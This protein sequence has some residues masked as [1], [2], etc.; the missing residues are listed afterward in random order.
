MAD[1]TPLLIVVIT[2]VSLWIIGKFITRL[3]KKLPAATIPAATSRGKIFADG[4]HVEE[5]SNVL[6]K[7]AQEIIT[8]Q[9]EKKL[10]YFLARYRPRIIEL[11]EFFAGLRSKYF[12]NLGKPTNLASESEKINA[13]TQIPLDN[14]PPHIDLNSISAAELR[15]LVEKNIKSN[16]TITTEFMDRFG[17]IDFMDNYQ[18]Y[19]QLAS[20]QNTAIHATSVHQYRKQLE[21]FVTTGV[22]Q[23]GRKIP[24]KDRL[25][26]LSF[27]QLKEMAVELKVN[28][29]FTTKSEIANTLAQMPGSAVHLSMIY[30]SDDIFLIMA[31]PGD[32]RNIEDEWRMLDAYAKLLIGSLRNTFV[33]FDEMAANTAPEVS[34]SE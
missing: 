32:A 13:V 18:V 5:M 20:Q 14:V 1:Q 10:V 27:E 26:V 23:Q 29:P 11:E 22:A 9:D 3:S 28:R 31:E 30:E 16:L 2:L 34:A 6:I 19:T 15:Y 33:S 7:E 24:L 17:G 21:A 12:T 25:E 8:Q 4:L